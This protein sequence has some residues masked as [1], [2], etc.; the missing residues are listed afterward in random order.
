MAR[1]FDLVPTQVKAVDIAIRLAYR[2]EYVSVEDKQW[3]ASPVGMAS[4]S[5]VWSKFSAVRTY[6]D[7]M[8]KTR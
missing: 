5:T 4:L 8:A 7:K 1:R 3:L 2:A 6:N